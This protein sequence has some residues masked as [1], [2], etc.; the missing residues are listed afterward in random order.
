MSLIILLLFQFGGCL[1]NKINNAIG[2]YGKMLNFDDVEMRD[3]GALV[4]LP[5]GRLR[6][7]YPYGSALPPLAAN[8]PLA[9]TD[10]D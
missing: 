5:K 8:S 6:C 7:V 4:S 3:G 10:A 2:C 9:Q 1:F